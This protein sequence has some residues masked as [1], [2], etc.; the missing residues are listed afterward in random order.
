MR[1]RAVAGD[2]NIASVDNPFSEEPGADNSGLVRGCLPLHDG[3]Q[4]VVQQNVVVVEASV[5]AASQVAVD[6]LKQ[7][8]KKKGKK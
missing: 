4:T 1:L 8:T 2:L 5:G 6:P 7:P 3:K